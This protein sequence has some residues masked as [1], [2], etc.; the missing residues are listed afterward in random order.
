VPAP[1]RGGNQLVTGT[2]RA[3]E[4]QTWR[5]GPSIGLVAI[6]SYPAAEPRSWRT[7]RHLVMA[8]RRCYLT[9]RSSPW[10][11]RLPVWPALVPASSCWGI[12]W[13]AWSAW[14]WPAPVRRAGAGGRRAGDQGLLVPGR[15]GPCPG[16]GAPAVGV[17]RL[18]AGVGR[19]PSA[20]LG[21][22]RGHGHERPG[23]GSRPAEQPGRW[24]LAM[25]PAAFAVAPAR[26]GP[27]TLSW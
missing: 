15:A 3:L 27:I 18:A 25:D 8:A 21:S 13:A 22:G 6:A 14:C 26:G 2:G 23:G 11:P 24:R 17:V 16:R 1:G 19:L 20:H 12:R 9:T 4:G 10:P 5:P 7:P